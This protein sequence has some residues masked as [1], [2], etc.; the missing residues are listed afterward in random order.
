MT[1]IERTDRIILGSS[2]SVKRMS[3]WHI[4]TITID[5]IKWND[6]MLHTAMRFDADVRLS[7][8]DFSVGMYE[9]CGNDVLSFDTEMDCYVYTYEGGTS[10]YL[11]RIFSAEILESIEN[12][13]WNVQAAARFA[14]DK[15]L[16][17]H[18]F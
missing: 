11:S 1:T 15:E 8:D 17:S 12:F 13:V 18:G 9:A 6:T 2:Y 14:Y 4:V 7:G 10:V 5:S 16:A 3:D